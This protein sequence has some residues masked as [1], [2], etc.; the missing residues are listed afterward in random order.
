MALD[1]ESLKNP[2]WIA[3][4]EEQWKV[5]EDFYGDD[6]TKK[7]RQHYKEYFFTGVI[8]KYQ[9]PMGA[10]YA[11][12]FFPI[13]TLEGHAY[14]IK[15]FSKMEFEPKTLAK[16]LIDISIGGYPTSLTLQ[17][18]VDLFTS[19]VGVEYDP[20]RKFQYLSKDDEDSSPLNFDPVQMLWCLL[21]GMNGFVESRF[22]S[23]YATYPHILDFIFSLLKVMNSS[24]FKY[25]VTLS[26]QEVEDIAKIERSSDC[27]LVSKQVRDLM[28]YAS[29]KHINRKKHVNCQEVLSEKLNMLSEIE[30]RFD[31][32]A[33]PEYP[34]ELIEHWQHIKSRNILIEI[35]FS[36]DDEVKKIWRRF[37]YYWFA[38][39]R[40]EEEPKNI[41]RAEVSQEYNQASDVFIHRMIADGDLF[42]N[43]LSSDWD[44]DVK[45]LFATFSSRTI[46]IANEL[47]SFFKTLPVD[48]LTF[49]VT[50]IR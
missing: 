40:L 29:L 21:Y 14:A 48:N 25:V 15:K 1:F 4:R 32:M 43:D 36:V 9:I 47:E 16:L 33:A 10:F 45:Y 6:W 31:A 44:S 2:E 35:S 49:K 28:C 8:N 24:L 5:F 30:H 13:Q 27:Y 22:S 11:I 46:E 20:N 42:F 7:D 19:Y 50:K 34:A 12:L 38:V 39:S 3:K 26:S 41:D 23:S 37:L 17:E 18:R